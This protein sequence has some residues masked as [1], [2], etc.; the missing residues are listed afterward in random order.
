MSGGWWGKWD[1]KKVLLCFVLAFSF[2]FFKISQM[3]AC[4]YDARNNPVKGENLLT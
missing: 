2:C 1:Q 4:L 3:I